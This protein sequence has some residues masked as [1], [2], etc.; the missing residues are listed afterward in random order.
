[1]TDKEM[2]HNSL[3]S[4]CLNYFGGPPALGKISHIVYTHTHISSPNNA[5]NHLSSIDLLPPLLPTTLTSIV[6]PIAYSSPHITRT[7]SSEFII[8][9]LIYG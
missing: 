9:I 2:F 5:L 3:P 8:S 7:K 6:V 4:L 1:M